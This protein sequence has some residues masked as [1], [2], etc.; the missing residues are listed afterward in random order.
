MH[1]F[2]GALDGCLTL[3]A[4]R[5][6]ALFQ[7]LTRLGDVRVD[8]AAQLFGL[9][10]CSF[11]RVLEQAFGVADQGM[12]LDQGV[13]RSLQVAAMGR[14]VDKGRVLPAGPS[15]IGVLS[16]VPKVDSVDIRSSF[17][18]SSGDERSR[19]LKFRACCRCKGSR[20]VGDIRLIEVGR[21]KIG[22]SLWQIW[23]ITKRK[24][25]EAGFLF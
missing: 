6:F 25:A 22:S 18:E 24:P 9:A 14:R 2:L 17:S 13:L 16:L 23:K 5:A 3:I 4:H 1:I 11:L 20:F 19:C 8:L 15:G 12:E 7:H 21:R 10:T